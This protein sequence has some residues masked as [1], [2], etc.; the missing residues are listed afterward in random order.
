MLDL[1]P[2]LKKAIKIPDLTKVK[3]FASHA[4]FAEISELAKYTSGTVWTKCRCRDCG[5]SDAEICEF[6]VDKLGNGVHPGYI[7]AYIYC[8]DCDD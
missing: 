3:K 2:N 6:Y 7:G 8:D 4:D 1:T 5:G